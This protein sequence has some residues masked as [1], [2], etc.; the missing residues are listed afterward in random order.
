[1]QLVL[2]L[3]R[4]GATVCRTQRRSRRR[5][6]QVS[7]STL[8]CIRLQKVAALYQPRVPGRAHTKCAFGARSCRPSALHANRR[9]PPVKAHSTSSTV[10][11][12]GSSLELVVAGDDDN[13]EHLDAHASA[14]LP[15][16]HRRI[17]TRGALAGGTPSG[18][19]PVLGQDRV[20]VAQL[21]RQVVLPEPLLL[22]A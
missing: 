4:S 11:G 21:S 19:G 14:I 16:P 20:T 12:S 1:M 15:L 22:M 2:S 8:L 13:V 7:L 6:A 17:N 3:S 5:A 18:G 9:E 10:V